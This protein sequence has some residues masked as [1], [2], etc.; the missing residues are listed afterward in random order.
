MKIIYRLQMWFY[1]EYSRPW[2]KARRRLRAIEAH[3]QRLA[4][5]KR[6]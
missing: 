5:L 1:I 2:D 4:R 3:E 6:S